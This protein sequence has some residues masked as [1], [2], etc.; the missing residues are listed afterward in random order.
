MIQPKNST[1]AKGVVLLVKKTD[2][3]KSSTSS[4]KDEDGHTMTW[5][6]KHFSSTKSF[7]AKEV[8][9]KVFGLLR[10]KYTVMVA[11]ESKH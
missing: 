8:H 1:K 7:A 11:K 5:L 10:I 2:E 6:P 4:L 3:E 9:S